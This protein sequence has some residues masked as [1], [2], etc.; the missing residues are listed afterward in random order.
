MALVGFISAQE[1][2]QQP[3][4]QTEFV[5][6]LYRLD[7]DPGGKADLVRAIRERG[8]G[9]VLTDG[10][11]SLTRTKSRNDIELRRTLEESERRRANP[12]ARKIPNSRVAAELLQVTREKTLA[13]LS[14]MPDFVVK[15]RIARSA[16]FAGT[17]N[18]R[19]LDRLV[20]AV[21]YR[22][23]GFEEYRTLSVNGIAQ[24]D[25]K[26]ERN[27]SKFGGTSSTGEFVTV[28]AT[29]FEPEN[30]AEFNAIDTDLLRGRESVV[31]EFSVARDKAKQVVASYAFDPESTI[32][33]M[34]GKLWIDRE[35]GRVIRLEST[36]TEIPAGFRISAASRDIDYGWV[37]I[38]GENFL[39]P[40]TSDVRLTFRQ[41]D[42]MFESRNLIRFKDYQKFGT[43]VIL[44]DDDDEPVEE[45]KRDG[46]EPP[47][48]VKP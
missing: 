16:A 44:L 1:P 30:E 26:A 29:I 41:G 27:Y 34:K 28:L 5:E 2:A 23:D 48:L 33:G 22:A 18:F 36:A 8:I 38:G 24:T 3:I 35:D 32:T 6:M 12:E 13:A 11:R 7:R 46:D 37:E 15:Q 40:T 20:V 43:E 10:L 17:N 39:L 31:F 25:P 19:S 9:F 47:P 4:S 21:S 42:K 45:P 14:D